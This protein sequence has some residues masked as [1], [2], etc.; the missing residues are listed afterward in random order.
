[1]PTRCPPIPVTLFDKGPFSQSLPFSF[2]L[3]QGL[4]LFY[5][6]THRSPSSSSV[7]SCWRISVPSSIPKQTRLNK[8]TFWYEVW[9]CLCVGRRLIFILTCHKILNFHTG[10]QN[11]GKYKH[12][13][14]LPKIS[15]CIVYQLPWSELEK[16]QICECKGT[17]KAVTVYRK[18]RRLPQ[19]LW[20]YLAEI[21][22][23]A[24]LPWSISAINS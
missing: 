6:D 24:E 13:V 7:T 22:Q 12:T 10:N 9:L 17:R 21:P 18:K 19:S 8:L 1:M 16:K 15:H 3:C 20:G 4:L 23:V 14:T 11:L 2:R 5:S